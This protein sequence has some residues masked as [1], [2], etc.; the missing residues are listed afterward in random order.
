M[1]PS[2]ELLIEAI[3]KI[4]GKRPLH[5]AS[6]ARPTMHW[7]MI[8]LVVVL[9]WPCACENEVSLDAAVIGGGLSGLTAALRL[10]QGGASVAL[11]D[12]A[13]FFGGNS[14]KASS[15]INACGLRGS[16]PQ[17][18]TANITDSPQHFYEDTMKSSQREPGSYTA[19][20]AK[21]MADSSFEVCPD[22]HPLTPPS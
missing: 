1:W 21:V 11:I 10:L 4:P 16:S 14:A 6:T 8:G 7:T 3:S 18:A 5:G 20:L 22:T 9:A 19:G 15:G 13:K 2:R 17:Q 12:K